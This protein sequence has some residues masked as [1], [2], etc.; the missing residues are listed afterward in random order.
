[1]GVATSTVTINGGTGGDLVD[2]GAVTGT[3]VDVVFN[4]GGGNDLF[5]IGLGNDT[6]TDTGQGEGNASPTFSCRPASSATA[7]AS[8]PSRGRTAP[9]RWKVLSSAFVDDVPATAIVFCW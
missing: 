2:A 1:M 6:F 7:G 8:G 4:G 5:K 9:T 3:P